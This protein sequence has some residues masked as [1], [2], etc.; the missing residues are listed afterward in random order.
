MEV[1]SLSTFADSKPTRY[2]ATELPSEQ[3]PRELIQ[4]GALLQYEMRQAQE[5]VDIRY[6]RVRA[7]AVH[8]LGERPPDTEGIERL[9]SVTKDLEA[10]R[11]SL[12]DAT[13]RWH[14]FIF[15]GNVLG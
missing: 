15:R 12:I 10:A 5:L 8:F 2:K 6:D 11:E 14:Y 7:I 4:P 1:V 3:R 13:C 9:R